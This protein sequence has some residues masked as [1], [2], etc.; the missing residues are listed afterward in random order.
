MIDL[1][2]LG[3]RSAIYN[4]HFVAPRL[5][6]KIRLIAG[7]GINVVGAGVLLAHSVRFVGWLI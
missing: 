2:T 5:G 4:V 3:N 1:N 7:L 6:D